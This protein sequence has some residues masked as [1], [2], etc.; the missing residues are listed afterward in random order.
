MFSFPDIYSNIIHSLYNIVLEDNNEIYLEYLLIKC[1][2]LADIIK[3]FKEEDSSVI[4]SNSCFSHKHSKSNLVRIAKIGIC[5]FSHYDKNTA[6]YKII[7]PVN[8]ETFSNLYETLL[9]PLNE[10][11]SKPLGNFKQN[12][13][14]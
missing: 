9:K 8:W 10:K 7:N 1:N 6:L 5:I 3:Y 4:L 14:N 12:H 2:L 13:S 11:I